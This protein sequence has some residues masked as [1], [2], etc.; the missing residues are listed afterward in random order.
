MKE[1]SPF[2][3]AAALV[4]VSSFSWY[5][6]TSDWRTLGAH[7]TR[8]IMQ[9]QITILISKL[10]QLSSLTFITINIYQIR[11]PHIEYNW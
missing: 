3:Q 7:Y 8:K 10:F 1:N 9:I 4:V 6:N 2:S 11:L 5:R